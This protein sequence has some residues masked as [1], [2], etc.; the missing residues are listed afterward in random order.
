[1]A[2]PDLITPAQIQKTNYHRKRKIVHLICFFIFMALPF[3]NVMRFDIPKQRFYFFGVELWIN[4]FGIIFFAMMFLMFVIVVSSVIYGRI[5]CSYACPQ[6]IFSEASLEIEK[7]ISKKVTKHFITWPAARRK[8]VARVAWLAV[9]GVASVFL[10]FIFISYFVEP[11]DLLAR[12]M[13][14]DVQTAGGISGAVVTLI[15]FLDFTLV[16]QTFCTTVCPYGYL[17]GILG[18]ANTL[19]VTYRDEK[20]ECIEC[21]KCVRVCEMG[22][23]IRKSPYQI[24][25]IHCGDCIDACGDVL[26]RLGKETLIHYTWG[27][28]GKAVVDETKWYRKLGIRDAK[29][30]VVLLVTLFYLSGL[31]V[32]LSMREKIMIQLQPVRT[33]MFRV[34]ENGMI[35]NRFR[36]RLVN[37]GSQA[38]A[39]TFQA[40]GLP[41]ANVALTP[42]PVPLQPGE[43]VE[44]EFDVS[45]KRFAGAP[46]VNHFRIVAVPSGGEKPESFDETFL[47]PEGK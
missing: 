17:Q 32:A 31:T 21:K 11:R 28:T 36:V 19:L 43:M 42:N 13:R 10:A 39:V 34:G 37:R 16:R 1:M 45:A 20:H 14:L 2:S 5:Y 46:A 30:V 23:D 35:H 12:L 7:W 47:M 25:C 22:I 4:E 40:E 27:E 38:T 3:S 44:R 6:M 9:L 29:R 8:L 41:G 18:D 15:T 24:E 33:T 26:S